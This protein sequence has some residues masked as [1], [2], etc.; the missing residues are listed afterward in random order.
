MVDSE[1]QLKI[2]N[3]IIDII[4][5]ILPKEL[6]QNKTSIILCILIEFAVN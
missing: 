3:T 5:Y 2:R 1:G 4:T 6:L